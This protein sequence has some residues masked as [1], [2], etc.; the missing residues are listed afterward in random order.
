MIK[1][2][3]RPGTARLAEKPY[4]LVAGSC[5]ER[6]QPARLTLLAVQDVWL[7][8]KDLFGVSGRCQNSH[9]VAKSAFRTA[10]HAIAVRRGTSA[11]PVFVTARPAPRRHP[12]PHRTTGGHQT[13]HH[14][15]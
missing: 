14:P 5:L 1:S 8:A 12:C 13:S 11:R 10:T 3:S 4:Q 6:D 15:C 7:V 9:G 2:F